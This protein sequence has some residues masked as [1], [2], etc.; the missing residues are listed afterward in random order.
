MFWGVNVGY[1]FLAAG[2]FVAVRT[3]P[4]LCGMVWVGSWWWGEGEGGLRGRAGGVLGNE[5]WAF[6]GKG[7][8]ATPL[9]RQHIGR[10]VQHGG[11]FEGVE[12]GTPLLAGRRPWETWP[13]ESPRG[14]RGRSVGSVLYSTQRAINSCADGG[15][16]QMMSRKFS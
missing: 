5:Q 14:R 1:G 16:H 7:D 10:S 2:N 3:V 9:A 8:A 11:G 15:I 12:G 13:T 4:A 6:K